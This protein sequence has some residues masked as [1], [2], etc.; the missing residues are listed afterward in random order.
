VIDMV[1]AAGGIEV[2]VELSHLVG[3]RFSKLVDNGG[4]LHLRMES[5]L[6]EQRKVWDRLVVPSQVTVLRVFKDRRA[7][8]VVGDSLGPIVET[9]DM[10]Q[11]V[12]L[13]LHLPVAG[14]RE[15][16]QY[17]LRASAKIGTVEQTDID[18]MSEAFLGEQGGG[19]TS[20]GKLFFR[21]VLQLSD[22]LQSESCVIRSEPIPGRKLLSGR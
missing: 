5:E 11:P 15:Q 3:P 13:Q 8:L 22:Y 4:V 14:I 20:F 19:L 16:G 2:I 18:N 10:T 21:K 6:W 9:P 1:G 17:Y 7:W 12:H